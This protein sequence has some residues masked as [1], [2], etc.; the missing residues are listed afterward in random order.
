MGK[1]NDMES[2]VS[3]LDK[4]NNCGRGEFIRKDNC[5]SI[6]RHKP[7]PPFLEG[8][9]KMKRLIMTI[10]L[11]LL[12]GGCNYIGF[13]GG[14]G[15]EF[16]SANLTVEYGTRPPDELKP[17]PGERDFMVTGGFLI[18]DNAV[19]TW[20]Y[21]SRPEMGS[22][23]K[24]GIEVAP[25]TGLFVN[26]LGGLTFIHYARYWQT[27]WETEWNGLFGGGVTYFINDKDVC[28]LTAYDN[29]RGF[30]AGIGF[31]F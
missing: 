22:F 12:S 15:G 13:A 18:I 20:F 9:C 17:K 19:E 24:L 5:A 4:P 7:R 3:N 30:T 16:D 11:F 8:R 2:I 28:F 6:E 1:I 29:R 14:Q 25:D 31:R 27:E 10:C 21:E 23:V 26:V